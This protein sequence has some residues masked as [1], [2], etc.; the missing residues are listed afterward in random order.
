M[1]TG[2]G[3]FS[4]YR[5][6]DGNH[7]AIVEEKDNLVRLRVDDEVL[8]ERLRG[9]SRYKTEQYVRNWPGH[10][11]EDLVGLDPNLEYWLD[12]DYRP[13]EGV[14]LITDVPDGVHISNQAFVSK[15]F[16]LVSFASTQPAEYRFVDELPGAS[17]GTFY[18]GFGDYP[19]V[20]GAIVATSPVQVGSRIRNAAIIM[21]PPYR[22][23][24]GGVVFSEFQL[25]VPD[26]PEVEFHFEVAL[27]DRPSRT[28]PALFAVWVNG[29]EIWRSF[30]G[31][32][33]WHKHVL[34]WNAGEGR[35]SACGSLEGL[36]R[37]AMPW[38]R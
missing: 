11:P 22:R 28:L 8:Y 23:I 2:Q 7:T 30:Y 9:V 27:A 6:R 15:E 16:A 34:H 38:M 13:A 12:P 5:S 4:V 18:R 1:L 14:P 26:A 3:G 25:T 21:H 32:G 20:N 31:V 37:M 24:L 33:Q 36:A 35:R 19:V 10:G 17:K 29:E